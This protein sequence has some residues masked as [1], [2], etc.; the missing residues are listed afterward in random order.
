MNKKTDEYFKIVKEIHVLQRKD[1]DIIG[2]NEISRMVGKDQSTI[3]HA[4]NP[5]NKLELA[6][7]I[8]SELKKKHHEKK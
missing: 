2:V 7:E 1:D 5:K 8:L 6:K 4:V 3:S